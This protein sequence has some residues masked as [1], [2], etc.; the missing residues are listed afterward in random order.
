MVRQ[1]NTGRYR[2]WAWRATQ[3]EYDGAEEI[4]NDVLQERAETRV[5]LTPTTETSQGGDSAVDGSGHAKR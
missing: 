4:L 2:L 3:R 5:F 1:K